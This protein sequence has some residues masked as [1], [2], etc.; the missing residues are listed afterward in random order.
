MCNN[1]HRD[2]LCYVGASHP[3]GDTIL[4]NMH[5]SHT[6]NMATKLIFRSNE[7]EKYICCKY[8]WNSGLEPREQM[9]I[10]CVPVL[11]SLSFVIRD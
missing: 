3:Q 8:F 9:L 4:A 7:I 5:F 10:F 2:V 6:Y 11:P 1:S